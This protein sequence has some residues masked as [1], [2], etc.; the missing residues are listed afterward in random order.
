MNRL[1]ILVTGSKGQLGSELSLLATTI[2]NHTF[3]F[4]D[5][6]EMDLTK[7]EAI[8]DFFRDKHFNFVI[9]CAAYT[10]VDK[11]EEDVQNAFLI[12]SEAVKVI[13]DICKAN[14]V[15]LIHIST[16]YV[17]DGFGNELIA[18]SAGPNPLSIYGKSKLLGEK[19][20]LETLP[21]AYVIR[22]AW[23]YSVFGKNFVK[24]IATLAQTREELKVVTDQIGSPTSARDLAGAIMNIVDAVN[25]R[26]AD[27]PGIYHYSNEGV[28]S[29]FDFAYFIVDHYKLRCKII[30][31][32]SQDYKTLAVRPKFTPLDK[33]KIKQTFDIK[34]PHWHTSLKK[35]LDEL[36]P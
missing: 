8:R 2:P 32:P 14:A 23:V 16:D 15:R 10:A 28:I 13:A 12:N 1:N 34:V 33:T 19:Y 11:A 30:A 26:T 35:C 36:K 17:F 9:H 29:W 18:E 31:I 3:Q 21:D 4:V 25:S 24:T 22:T 7:E 6:D 5:V 20:V 27:I